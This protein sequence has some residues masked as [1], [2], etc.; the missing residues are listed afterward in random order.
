MPHASDLE[1]LVRL[2]D[3]SR[4]PSTKLKLL[5]RS[6]S[7]RDIER[8][9]IIFRESNRHA[10]DT[11]I[12]LRGTAELR[13]VSER[14]SRTVA[15]L[16]PGVMFRP[17]MLS[18]EV[19]HDFE[20]SALSDCLVANLPAPLFASILLGVSSADYLQAMERSNRK[21]GKLLCRYPG[22]VGFDLQRRVATALIELAAE[23]GVANHRGTMLPITISQSRLAD[24][25][26]ASRAKVGQ[27]LMNLER[28][29]MVIREERRLVIAVEALKGLVQSA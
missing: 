27:T 23:F 14:R 12:L 22:F 8:G 17:P 21:M 1:L 11:Y 5:D 16:S 15:I 29:K 7:V 4:L 6:M 25:V 26:G 28:R 10:P 18:P 2:N 13:Y 19:G 9:R 20:W 3:F 24:L